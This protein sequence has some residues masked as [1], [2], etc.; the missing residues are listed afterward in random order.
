MSET[1]KNTLG[2]QF[3]LHARRVQLVDVDEQPQQPSNSFMKFCGRC[4]EMQMH[5]RQD[6][7][8]ECQCCGRRK[9]NVQQPAAD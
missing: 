1:L 3:V 9:Y 5:T 6:N 7:Y 2:T 8:T 4:G